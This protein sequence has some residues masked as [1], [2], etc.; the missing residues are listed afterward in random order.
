MKKIAYF[1]TINLL[2][3]L[4]NCSAGTPVKEK[5]TGTDGISKKG[6]VIHLTS[7]EFKKKV[8]DYSK[9]K[10]WK[11]EGSLPCIIDF[12][13]TWCGPCRIMS[14]RLDEIALQYAGKL[15]VYKIDTDKEQ[16]LSTVIGIQSLPTL[17]FCPQKGEPQ[18]SIGVITKEVLVENIKSKLLVK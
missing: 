4:V 2:L 12:Y 6:M 3:L 17:L 10:T 7:E 11:Y 8:F 9:N 1:I 16:E 15:I 5:T 14:P 18:A 13:A